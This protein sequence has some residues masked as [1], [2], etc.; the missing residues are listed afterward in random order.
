[1]TEGPNMT[2]DRVAD[3]AALWGADP[4]LWPDRE[5]AAE[6]AA[7]AARDADARAALEGMAALDEA[8]GA[9]AAAPPPAAPEALVA[10]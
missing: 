5:A 7:L 8:L 4:A 9:L 6:A 1:M 3:L 2:A 10:R